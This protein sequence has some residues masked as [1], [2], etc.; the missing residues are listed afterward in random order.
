MGSSSVSVRVRV[1]VDVVVDGSGVMVTVTSSSVKAEVEAK[2]EANEDIFASRLGEVK[3][4]TCRCGGRKR[5]RLGW[6]GRAA[7]TRLEG[8]GSRA[9]EETDGTK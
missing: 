3:R 8:A 2:E 7:M 9:W 6:L 5:M 4:L 1:T